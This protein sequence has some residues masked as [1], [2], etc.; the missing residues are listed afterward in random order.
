[1][2]IVV[3]KRVF[4]YILERNYEGIILKTRNKSFG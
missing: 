2:N 3:D 1:M 4:D